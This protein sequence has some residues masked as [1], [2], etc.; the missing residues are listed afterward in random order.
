M[1]NFFLFVRCR[2]KAFAQQQATAHIKNRALQ[3]SSTLFQSLLEINS[4][5]TK[6]QAWKFLASPIRRPPL[7]LS[8][9]YV[10]AW[11]TKLLYRF[12]TVDEKDK[13]TNEQQVVLCVTRTHTHAPTTSARSPF[14]HARLFCSF[15]Q[16]SSHTTED[17]AFARSNVLQSF[18]QSYNW[19]CNNSLS[20]ACQQTRRVTL[21]KRWRD[22]EQICETVWQTAKQASKKMSS[23][24]KLWAW[25]MHNVH[26]FL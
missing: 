22:N 21:R 6:Q 8:L 12:A 5:T 20:C 9:A 18:A 4:I 1:F 7:P 25:Q 3:H 11:W 16:I 2:T 24:D 23:A 19:N 14:A 15:V 10:L 17:N 13:V 26:S